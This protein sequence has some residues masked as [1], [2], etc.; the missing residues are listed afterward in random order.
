MPVRNGPFP[1]HR[2][3]T[4]T[5]GRPAVSNSCQC[6][7]PP[8]RRPGPS[9]HARSVSPRSLT[10]TAG[11]LRRDSA[12]P[13]GRPGLDVALVLHRQHLLRLEATGVVRPGVVEPHRA[14]LEPGD[15]QP[16]VRTD[17]DLAS[18]D[19]P[20]TDHRLRLAIDLLWSGPISGVG[21]A[22]DM[23]QVTTTGTTSCRRAAEVA[24]FSV[25]NCPNT[26][27]SSWLHVPP[28]P[29]GTPYTVCGA[30]PVRSMVLSS[31][32]VKNPMERLS[33]DQNGDA[34]SSV[35]RRACDSNES[36]GRIHN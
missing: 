1:V 5:S 27:T 36:S 7:D 21:C 9:P 14:L 12:S 26:I 30:P 3:K 34:A 6:S 24:D 18:V 15:V 32:L 20:N 23:K 2:G 31:V 33:G 22:G 4:P 16:A 13:T 19:R 35:P 11:F 25:R 29:A 28:T 17:G 8:E 10:A